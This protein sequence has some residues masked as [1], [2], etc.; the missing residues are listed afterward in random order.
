MSS[1]DMFI[2]R[3]TD[4][5]AIFY[6][7]NLYRMFFFSMFMSM[8][9]ANTWLNDDETIY[10]V[11]AFPFPSI[12]LKSYHFFRS[13]IS[14]HFLSQ[15]SLPKSPLYN[16]PPAGVFSLPNPKPQNPTD[17]LRAYDAARP[18]ATSPGRPTPRRPS[19]PSPRTALGDPPVAWCTST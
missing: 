5:F 14:I 8:K 3:K 19:P 1:T 18:S 16:T 4:Y 13:S 9:W 2:V 11:S 12:S 15:T 17:R 6:G 10:Y 7:N